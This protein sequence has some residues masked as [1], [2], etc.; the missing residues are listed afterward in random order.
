MSEQKVIV[1]CDGGCSANGAKINRGGWG[2]VLKFGEQ[3]KTLYGGE[4]NTTNQRMELT[5]CIKALETVKPEYPVDLYSDSA[6]LINCFAAKWYVNWRKN[7]WLSA[8]KQPVENRDLWERLL[9]LAGKRTI[10]F[11]KVKGHSGDKL[12]EMADSLAQKGIAEI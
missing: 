9:D 7:G 3:T 2:A 8:K 6:Y 12:N 10:A 4:K 1:Y 11:H 5:A